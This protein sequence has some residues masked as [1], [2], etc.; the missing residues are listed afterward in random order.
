MGLADPFS[1]TETI[2]AIDFLRPLNCE[3]DSP[4]L[5]PNWSETHTLPYDKYPISIH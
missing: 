5:D 3:M 1:N 2:V 4:V